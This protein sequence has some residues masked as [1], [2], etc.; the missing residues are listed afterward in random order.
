[1]TAAAG[2]WHPQNLHR[3][4]CSLLTV[5]KDHICTLSITQRHI[6]Q[7]EVNFGFWSPAR[8][9][10]SKVMV[11]FSSLTRYQVIIVQFRTAL[12]NNVPGAQQKYLSAV[13][14]IA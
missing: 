11:T 13:D 7:K 9:Y 2:S 1:M 5:K 3:N 14:T 8:E 12:S 10:I 4:S 6:V